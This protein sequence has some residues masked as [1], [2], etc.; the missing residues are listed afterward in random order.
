MAFNGKTMVC[1]VCGTQEQAEP[2]V[3]LN[4]QEKSITGV[5]SGW[6]AFEAGEHSFCACPD[7]FPSDGA[8]SQELELAYTILLICCTK[9]HLKQIGILPS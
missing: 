1:I 8:T 3:I 6:R 5:E 2:G 4:A 7:E 9:K